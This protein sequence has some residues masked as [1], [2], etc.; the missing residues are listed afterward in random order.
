MV[1]TELKNPNKLN[2]IAAKM[3]GY[4]SYEALQPL[5][6]REKM[7]QH[8]LHV[9]RCPFQNNRITIKAANIIVV[10]DDVEN[11]IFFRPLSTGQ[12]AEYVNEENCFNFFNFGELKMNMDAAE[13]QLSLPSKYLLDPQI[14]AVFT[15]AEGGEHAFLVKRTYEGLIFDIIYDYKGDAGSMDTHAAAFDDADTD[16]FA[17]QVSPLL[18]RTLPSNDGEYYQ[19]LTKIE[20]DDAVCYIHINPKEEVDIS[21]VM[22]TSSKEAIEAINDEH[23]GI[24]PDEILERNCVLVKITK[25]LYNNAQSL[26]QAD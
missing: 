9:E 18:N 25:S 5:H 10:F 3:L 24:G 7:I 17:D 14:D 16:H 1:G 20:I 4:K 22:F 23:W 12:E 19:W 2:L 8:A 11:K 15:D 6:H 21:D 26:I 13:Y